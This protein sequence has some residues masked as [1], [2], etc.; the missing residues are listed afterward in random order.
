MAIVTKLTSTNDGR[1]RIETQDYRS[2]FS[3]EDF[4]SDCAQSLDVR[5]MPVRPDDETSPRSFTF[6]G[7]AF[8]AAWEDAHGSH[9]IGSEALRSVMENMRRRL[10]G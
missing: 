3:F 8:L 7:H 10:A 2:E 5:L 1:L 6:D 9:V 4:C